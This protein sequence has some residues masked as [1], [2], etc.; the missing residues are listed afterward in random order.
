MNYDADDYPLKADPSSTAVP[1]QRCS[2][3]PTTR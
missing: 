3:D 1:T 2:I